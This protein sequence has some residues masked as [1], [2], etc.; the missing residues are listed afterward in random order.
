MGNY[1][2]GNF[3]ITFPNPPASGAPINSQTVL[4]QPSIPQ[5]IL[6]YDGAFVLRPVPDQA[7]RITVEAFIR[8]TELLLSTDAP[9]LSEWWQYIAY[10]AAK[11]V[12]EDR[13]DLESVQ[14]IMP[15]YH[16]QML[17]IQRRTIVQQTNQRTSTIFTEQTGGAGLYGGGWFAGG[18]LF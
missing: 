5:T 2:T 12:F 10:G 14:Q 6:F 13:M 17:L 4:V 3:T 1:V 8:P 18:S 15:E 7:Y 16:K 11:K 9:K